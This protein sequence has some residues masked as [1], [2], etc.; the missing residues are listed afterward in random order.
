M[1]DQYIVGPPTYK[2]GDQSPRP[3][4]CCAYEGYLWI[5]VCLSRRRILN[6][7]HHGTARDAASVH[8]CPSVPPPGD[9]VEYAP[10]ALL[11]SEKRRDRRTDGRTDRRNKEYLYNSSEYNGGYMGLSPQVP[12]IAPKHE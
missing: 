1:G 10:R 3:Y 11:G 5:Y 6:V 7:T 4:G 8:F 2:L 12:Q 9:H